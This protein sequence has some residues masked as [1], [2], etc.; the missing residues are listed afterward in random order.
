MIVTL[1]NVFYLFFLVLIICFIYWIKHIYFT[2][3]W[4]KQRFMPE[5]KRKP[6]AESVK[7]GGVLA[8]KGELLSRHFQR[9]VWN[10]ITVAT[11]TKTVYV[12]HLE[13]PKEAK[14]CFRQREFK[15][16]Q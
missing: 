11:T 13:L 15:M 9:Y 4:G 7:Q 14:I 3:R 8:F 6:S 2:G 12:C 16:N 10:L 1:K 5:R